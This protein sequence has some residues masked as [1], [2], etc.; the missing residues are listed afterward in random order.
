MNNNGATEAADFLQDFKAVPDIRSRVSIMAL[1]LVSLVLPIGSSS[2]FGMSASFRLDNEAVLGSWSYW[3]TLISTGCVIAPAF[4]G[5]KSATRVIDVLMGAGAV[6]AAIIVVAAFV[7]GY[8]E[9]AMAGAGSR[10]LFGRSAGV[11][12]FVSF[13]P[14]VGAA[15][16][17]VLVVLAAVRGI[18]ALRA[19]STI[20]AA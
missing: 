11:S 19:N 4:D 16:F 17:A 12:S 3:L 5:T 15:P 9:I 14:H 13:G 1:M 8:D 2:A 18:K 6:L 7:R 10:A 20:A